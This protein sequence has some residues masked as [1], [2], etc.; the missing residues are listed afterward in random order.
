MLRG[1]AKEGH[2]KV[3][4]RKGR[5]KQTQHRCQL[6]RRG[7]EGQN[8]VPAVFQQFFEPPFGGAAGPL[9]GFIGNVL[10]VKAH[11]AEQPLGKAEILR[12]LQQR[13]PYGA[14]EGAKVG[15]TVHKIHF[16]H[17]GGHFVK[18]GFH[19]G[20]QLV[21][22]PGLLK[23]AHAV[24][25][26]LCVQNFCHLLYDGRILLQVIGDDA[27]IQALQAELSA[28]DLVK[29]QAMELE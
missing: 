21:L 3:D 4:N 6:Q 5:G 12:H 10:G 17:I 2:D 14:A 11:P 26:R 27:K 15:S 7:G 24:R 13:I 25:V 28:L 29:V 1:L 16:A 19:G 9:F 22:V 18:S 20:H 8:A 23:G